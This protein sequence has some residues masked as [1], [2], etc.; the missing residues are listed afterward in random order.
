MLIL[1]ASFKFWT[2]QDQKKR[3]IKVRKRHCTLAG[4][5]N[6]EKSHDFYKYCWAD[7]FAIQFFQSANIRTILRK[8]DVTCI[9]HLFIA[10][11]TLLVHTQ[12]WNTQTFLFVYTRAVVSIFFSCRHIIKNL[13]RC[14]RHVDIMLT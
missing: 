7:L 12:K 10:I 11:I 8:E 6:N 4:M 1:V 9:C 3:W 13:P 14:R 2:M 5:W